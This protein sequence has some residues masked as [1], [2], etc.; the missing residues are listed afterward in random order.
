MGK[1]I[2]ELSVWYRFFLGENQNYDVIKCTKKYL[3]EEVAEGKGARDKIMELIEMGRE[4]LALPW[5]V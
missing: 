5:F 2:S 4:T 3:F 1:S